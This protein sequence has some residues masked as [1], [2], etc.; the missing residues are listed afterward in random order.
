MDDNMTNRKMP[1]EWG[2]KLTAFQQLLIIKAL[3]ENFL[4]LVVRHVVEAEMGSHY[5]VSPPFDLVGCFK[6]SKK[7]MPLI[8][9]LSRAEG[10]KSHPD[11]SRVR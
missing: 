4:Q 5:I 6:D 11:G 3:R 8:F 10:G 7:T 1:G 9:V 2:S